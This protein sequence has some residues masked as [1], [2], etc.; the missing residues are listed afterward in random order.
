MKDSDNFGGLLQGTVV[1]CLTGD[2]DR[3]I[4]AR[5]L[6]SDDIAVR[7]FH[8]DKKDLCN[9]VNMKNGAVLYTGKV[10]DFKDTASKLSVTF[11]SQGR[12]GKDYLLQCS[13]KEGGA[14]ELRMAC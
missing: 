12:W 4:K 1:Q 8:E 2:E 5:V 14:F 13:K 6:L 11:H 10:V 9:V 3:R 7:V